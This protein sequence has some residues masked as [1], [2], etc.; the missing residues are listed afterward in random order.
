MTKNF[1]AYEHVINGWIQDL[2]DAKRKVSG[3]G[4][5]EQFEKIRVAKE[6]F[7]KSLIVGECDYSDL[8]SCFD[9]LLPYCESLFD[10]VRKGTIAFVTVTE[11]VAVAMRMKGYFSWLS[12]EI[13]EVSELIAGSFA[14]E[15]L[16]TRLNFSFPEELVGYDCSQYDTEIYI[17]AQCSVS[18][19]NYVRAEKFINLLQGRRPEVSRMQTMRM[20]ILP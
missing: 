4:K 7:F 16:R 8:K 1:D 11:L 15:G 9:A 20:K 6:N 5:V 12:G 13:D 18:L 14:L 3:I 10:N 17:L 2:A 19:R